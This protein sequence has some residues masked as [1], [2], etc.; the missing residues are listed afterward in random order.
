MYQ[1]SSFIE[2]GCCCHCLI[3]T[4]ATANLPEYV[5]THSFK[6]DYLAPFRT[7]HSFRVIVQDKKAF[8][9]LNACIK[10][11]LGSGFCIQKWSYSEPWYQCHLYIYSWGVLCCG[12]LIRMVLHDRAF[13]WVVPGRQICV[14]PLIFI[15]F[16]NQRNAKKTTR[17]SQDF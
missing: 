7:R 4:L 6:T 10:H 9:G 17:I 5:A 13:W 12:Y 16:S 11:N 8:Q 15:S 2:L 14:G 1:L 3:K